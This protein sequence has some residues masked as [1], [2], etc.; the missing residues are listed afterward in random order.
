MRTRPPPE[1]ALKKKFFRGWSSEVGR[2]PSVRALMSAL[3]GSA[4]AS[5]IV[6]RAF[7]AASSRAGEGTCLNLNSEVAALPVLWS[8]V[9]ITC[10]WAVTIRL[11]G[12][13]IAKKSEAVRW[14]HKAKLCGLCVFAGNSFLPSKMSPAN[15]KYPAKAQRRKDREARLG[16]VRYWERAIA[17]YL[18][19]SA[20]SAAYKALADH[21]R[22]GSRA[23]VIAIILIRGSFG[24]R[25]SRAP[26]GK[27]IA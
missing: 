13:T 4:S 14:S 20:R 23:A 21:R 25:T 3:F 9:I 2:V 22:D 19:R 16:K 15:R 26:E 17:D 1:P 7:V 12:M 27:S 10:A 6:S 11:A 8:M 18:F 5:T 24:S